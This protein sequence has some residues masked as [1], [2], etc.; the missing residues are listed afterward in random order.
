M[1]SHDHLAARFGNEAALRLAAIVPDSPPVSE[2]VAPAPQDRCRGALLG[3]AVCENLLLTMR[4]R[5]GAIGPDTTMA[6]VTADS[7]LAGSARHPVRFAARLAA[8]NV[9]AI[10]EAGLTTRALLR[11]GRPW[12]DV[13]KPDSAGAGAAA[14]TVGIGLLWAGS[15][16]RAAY[17]AALSGA[18]THGHP[19][20]T[21]GAA[22]IAAAVA[23]A[24]HGD[25]HLDEAWLR[26][27]GAIA[28]PY[29]R[30][31][32]RGQSVADAVAR[33]AALLDRHPAVVFQELGDDSLVTHA[34]PAA[35]CWAAIALPGEWE[36]HDP[37]D[38]ADLRV[39]AGAHPVL[40][41]MAGAMVGAR[42]GA[43]V[44]PRR[45]CRVRGTDGAIRT[46]DRI[47][48][49][50]VRPKPKP[51]PGESGDNAPV[52]VSFLID[53]SGSMQG[54]RRDVVDGFNDFVEDQRDGAGECSLTLV[55]FDSEDPCEVILDAV[56]LA[57]VKPL[58]KAQYEPRAM[59]PLLDAVGG[60]IQRVDAR[61]DALNGKEDQVVV[62]F[63]D[64]LENAS[65]EWSR[66]DLF[67]R[68]K[69]R[70]GDGW[71]FVFLGANQDS[72]AAG[73]GLGLGDGSIQDFA[74]DAG[75]VQHA[76]RDVAASVRHYREASPNRR[77][78][79]N[80]AFLEDRKSAEADLRRKRRA[81]KGAKAQTDKGAKA[82]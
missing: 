21:A 42:H 41:A 8:G 4:G 34:V 55:Q 19:E 32:I 30:K 75:G 49:K 72:Y 39:L 20:A 38:S 24:A 10:G 58:T 33:A 14:R 5:A 11:Q 25:G 23:L 48:G 50:R 13:A 17:E 71:S 28:R 74:A 56:P 64:G 18:V 27:A 62:V 3:M 65:R 2:A 9:R 53:R 44:W 67:D 6:L 16:E 73:Q 52:H 31:P 70:Q 1:N 80:T 36:R 59:T 35:L 60:L 54:L 68:I 46:A 26:Q 40:G 51:A 69:E 15:P 66:E 45:L 12:W 29:S 81:A 7:A 43:G 63:T 77:L 37:Q 82:K 57:N 22:A 47:A 79:L 78:A 76:Y 61:L